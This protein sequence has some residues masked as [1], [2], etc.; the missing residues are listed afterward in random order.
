MK[1]IVLFCGLIMVLFVTG[2]ENTD[3]VICT[4]KMSGIRVDMI[5]TFVD[6]K[7]DTMKYKYFADLTNYSD[8]Q[9]N[10]IEKQD[11]CANA[12]NVLGSYSGAVKNCMKEFVNRTLT[13]TAEFDLDKL[14]GVQPGHRDT[15]EQSIA[16][17]EQQGYKCEK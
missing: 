5:M 1:K 16:S 10:E 2:C 15:K 13:V 3:E 4:Q 9:V 7:M 12:Q 8:E 17:L 11:V 14:P 6:N